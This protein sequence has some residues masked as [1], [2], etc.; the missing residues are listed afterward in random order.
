LAGLEILGVRDDKSEL[1]DLK[2]PKAD[3]FDSNVEC[4]FQVTV[5]NGNTV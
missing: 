5:I 4:E 1:T 2:S 3:G